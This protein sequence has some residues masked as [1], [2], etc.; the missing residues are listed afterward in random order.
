MTEAQGE[1]SATLPDGTEAQVNLNENGNTWQ[2]STTS[3]N[4]SCLVARPAGWGDDIIELV[5]YQGSYYAPYAVYNPGT[6]YASYNY[7]RWYYST[8]GVTFAQIT[9]GEV[10][11]VN[12]QYVI[13]FRVS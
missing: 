11:T 2:S 12:G 5:Y 8:W 3:D 6:S 4:V 7:M 9:S 1:L 13:W 10:Y